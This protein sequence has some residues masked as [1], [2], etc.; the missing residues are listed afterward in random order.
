MLTKADDDFFLYR[1]FLRELYVQRIAA[2][3][4]LCYS[5]VPCPGNESQNVD[6]VGTYSCLC[7]FNNVHLCHVF[8]AVVRHFKGICNE[9]AAVYERVRR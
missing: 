4:F 2:N 9:I 1:S 7:V 8:I 6:S 5:C 3:S